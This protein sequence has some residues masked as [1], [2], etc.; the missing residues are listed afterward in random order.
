MI[1]KTWNRFLR[2]SELIYLVDESGDIPEGN[3]Q[4]LGRRSPRAGWQS[5]MA[6]V[7]Y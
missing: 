3:P 6:V 5:E 4:L 1:E 2:R 7:G